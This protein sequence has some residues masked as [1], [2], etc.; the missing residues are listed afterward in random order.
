[1][2]DMI[3]GYAPWILASYPY[4]ND[5]TQPWLKGYKQHPFVQHQWRYYDVEPRPH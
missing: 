4:E 1:M 3:F 2:N 5:V